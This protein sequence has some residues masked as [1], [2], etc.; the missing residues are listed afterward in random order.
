MPAIHSIPSIHLVFAVCLL[1]Y[2]GATC[3][4]AEVTPSRRFIEGYPANKARLMWERNKQL[5]E[6]RERYKRLHPELVAVPIIRR[7][8]P[9]HKIKVGFEEPNY[10]LNPLVEQA[11]NQWAE[12]SGVVFDFYNEKGKYRRFSADDKDF[13]ADIRISYRESAFWSAVGCDSRNPDLFTPDQAS[14]NLEDPGKLTNK[15][16]EAYFVGAV[17]HEFGH[18]LGAEHEH[19]SP[20]ATCE[21]EIRWDDDPGYDPTTNKNGELIDD[22][23]GRRPG[24]YSWYSGYYLY[25]PRAQVD[26]DIRRELRHPASYYD[27]GPFDKHSIMKYSEQEK[28][29][30]AGDK[31][32]CY[33]EPTNQ[34]SEEDRRRIKIL[35]PKDEGMQQERRRKRTALIDDLKPEAQSDPRL[36]LLVNAIGCNL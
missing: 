5:A 15:A 23:K 21:Q 32:Q 31:S 29:Y 10:W 16:H 9:G 22:Q 8:P 18:A 14:M 17:L 3:C 35:Y 13:E 36:D 7:W 26:I 6:L 20:V 1:V 19:Q 24:L 28:F 2:A 27:V 34:L 33:A 4:A 11:A 30:K 12:A 25:W